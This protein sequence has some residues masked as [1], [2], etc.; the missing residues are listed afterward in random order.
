[1]SDGET[2]QSFMGPPQGDCKTRDEA[3]FETADVRVPKRLCRANYNFKDRPSE[4]N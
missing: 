2:L 4:D 3:C 1:M